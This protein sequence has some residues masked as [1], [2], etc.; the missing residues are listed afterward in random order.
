MGAALSIFSGPYA[1]LARWAVIAFL[2]AAFGGWSYTKGVDRESD[3]R[4]AL[5]LKQAKI[6]HDGHA[7]A[8]AYGVEQARKA[9]VNQAAA[10]EYQ[11]KWKEQRNAAKRS[12]T[13][14]AVVDGCTAGAGSATAGSGLKDPVGPVRLRLTWEFVSLWDSAYTGSDG[15]PLFGDTA[16]TEKTA[17]GP[18]AA[19]PY[20]AD[21]VLDRHEVN[22]A[23][24]DTCR[25]QLR[26]L[27][28]TIDGLERDWNVRHAR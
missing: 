9:Q 5:E 4:D 12:G 21:D 18:G 19:S 22:T 20:T 3:R 15:Q 16:R 24:W 26:A 7:K 25:R 23:R 17:A 13:P 10:D 28:E 6:E 14:L 1:V 2:V 27:V 8:V 11:Q